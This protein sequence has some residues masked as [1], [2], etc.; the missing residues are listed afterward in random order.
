MNEIVVHPRPL[1][2]R[3][4]VVSSIDGHRQPC[5]LWAAEG[6]EARPLLV[7]LHTWGGTFEQDLP[8]YINAGLA[9]NW[10]IVKPHFRGPNWEPDACGSPLARAD[11]LDAVAWAKQQLRVDADRVYITG[12]SGG[13]HMTLRMAAQA[14][15]VFAAASSWC[16]ISDLAAWHREHVKDGQEDKY[17]R[18]IVASVGGVPGSSQQVDR[19]IHDRSP[20][21]HMDAARALPLD[22]NHG[23]HDGKKGSVPFWHAIWAFN[24]IAQAL[25]KAEVSQREIDELWQEGRLAQPSEA[26]VA[27]D[28]AYEGRAIY[29][30]RTAG[31]CRLTIFEGGHEGVPEAGCAWMAQFS[32]QGPVAPEPLRR[33]ADEEGKGAAHI[34]G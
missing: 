3:I 21:F 12:G 34:A 1:S 29:L 19:E 10:H 4:E 22:I 26:D 11:V 25:G 7:V 32:R 6:D 16:G 33:V 2:Q 13:G 15:G 5:L 20:V 28:P 17:A 14:P 18:D 30:R 9:R 24:R 8:E 23:V 31:P 27:S